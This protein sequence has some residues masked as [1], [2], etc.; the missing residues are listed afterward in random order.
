VIGSMN[1][2]ARRL[3]RRGHV[4]RLEPSSAPINHWAWD[5]FPLA[6]VAGRERLARLL[7][8]ARGLATFCPLEVRWRNTNRY[9]EARRAKR[10]IAY[11]WHPGVIFVGLRWPYPWATVMAPAPVRHVISIERH[12]P[13]RMKT[14]EVGRLIRIMDSH[15]FVRP[16]HERWM[17]TG[18]E[19][20]VGDA[21]RVTAGPFE[22][23]ELRVQQISG[24]T[25]LVFGEFFGAERGFEIR[26][27]D[28]VRAG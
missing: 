9:D 3:P 8:E 12:R 23:R 10:Q 13:R 5:W 19:F 6:V 27:Q 1:R 26:L 11:P 2:P 25:A 28:L 21:V 17:V 16:D 24:R 18:H 20:D 7:L 15:R 4:T 22:G 14:A